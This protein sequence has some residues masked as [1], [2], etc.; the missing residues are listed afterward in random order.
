MTESKPVDLLRDGRAIYGIG[1]SDSYDI[2]ALALACGADPADTSHGKACEGGSG[3]ASWRP[4][5]IAGQA[6]GSRWS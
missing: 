2:E 6:D 5:P 1:I 4:P 3:M